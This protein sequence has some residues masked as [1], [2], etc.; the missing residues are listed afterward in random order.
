MQGEGAQARRTTSV[1]CAHPPDP[2]ALPAPTTNH[3]SKMDD[4][5]S[6]RH[7]SQTILVSSICHFHLCD[8]RLP[9]IFHSVFPPFSCYLFPLWYK[10]FSDSQRDICP[11]ITH[12]EFCLLPFLPCETRC[13]GT[14]SWTLLGWLGQVLL[15]EHSWC[16]TL[17]LWHS[18]DTRREAGRH[19][20]TLAVRSPGGM[21]PALSSSPKVRFL[22]ERRKGQ[23]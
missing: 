13:P 9:C 20:L 3:I 14:F 11:D 12:H 8:I 16:D 23:A 10:C 22:R 17:S 6:E 7:P 4:C 5:L 15:L 19:T 2:R 18:S 1:C 21:S